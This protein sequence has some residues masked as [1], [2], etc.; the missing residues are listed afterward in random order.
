M[1]PD[2]DQ[3]PGPPATAAGPACRDPAHEAALAA[4]A[5]VISLG[6]RWEAGP[7]EARVAAAEL[8]DAIEGHI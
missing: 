4:L 7:P 2:R 5:R 6:A 1:V 8:Q 3:Q